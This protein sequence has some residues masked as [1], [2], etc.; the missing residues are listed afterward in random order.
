M[1]WGKLMVFC[2]CFGL[3]RCCVMCIVFDKLLI[4][5][6][7][8]FFLK[9]NLIINGFLVIVFILNLIYILVMLRINVFI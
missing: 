3:I 6:G 5:I 1:I 2:S 7:N 8:K 9:L 4:S